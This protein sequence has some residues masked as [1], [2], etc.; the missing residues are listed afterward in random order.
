V[1]ASRRYRIVLGAAIVTAG[2]TACRG[3]PVESPER[4]AAASEPARHLRQEALKAAHV[5]TAPGTPPGTVDFSRNT[6]PGA[7]DAAS[8]VDCEFVLKPVGGTTP[9]FYCRLADG[10]VVK[11]K[12]GETNPEIP[13]DVAAS[14]LLSALGFYVDRMM[15][16]NSVRCRGCPP[17][18]AQ[19]LACIRSGGASAMCLQGASPAAVRTFDQAMI[20]RPFDGRDIETSD[21]DGWAWFELDSID[22]RAGGA[23]HAEVDALR[24]MAVLLAHW[25]NKSSNQRLVCPPGADGPDGACRSPAAVMHDL[26][27]TFGP[28][29]A[30]LQNWKRTPIWADAATCRTTMKSLPYKG[31][32]FGDP[33]IS[34]GGRRLVVKLLRSLSAAQL[35]TLFE[36]S[37]FGSFPHVLATAAQPQA[38]TDA[39]LAKVEEIASAGPCPAR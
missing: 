19:A 8:D 23:S 2:V 13:A 22:A 5:W 9:K 33:Q 10:Q 32:T 39:F 18:P 21:T 20:E 31:G 4:A 37:R 38:W 16:V 15:L 26:G 34:E 24:L 1:T 6:G 29:K 3:R 25:D 27:A 11:V 12:Y 7:L 35:N 14:R 17:F 30:D 28:L 36:A